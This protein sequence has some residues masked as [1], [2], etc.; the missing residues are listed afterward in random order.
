MLARVFRLG[1]VLLWPL[2]ILWGEV[3]FRIGSGEARDWWRI[4]PILAAVVGAA[5]WHLALALVAKK[6]DRF[7]QAMYAIANLPLLIVTSAIYL[8]YATRSPL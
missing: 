1:P 3:C 7:G 2:V 5:I 4:Y 6:E 8:L